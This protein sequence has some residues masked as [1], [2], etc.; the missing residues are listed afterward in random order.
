MRR[1]KE[2]HALFFNSINDFKSFLSE[3]TL[4]RKRL[5]IDPSSCGRELD[6]KVRFMMDKANKLE[7]ELTR[8]EIIKVRSLFRRAMCDCIKKSK[9]LKRFLEKPLGYP[10]D[11]FM[12]EMIYNQ[13]ILSKNKIG[14]YFDR[15]VLTHPVAQSMIERKECIKNLI[16]SFITSSNKK[17]LNILNLGCGSAR[18]LKELFASK[19]YSKKLI[20][21]LVDQDNRAL[22]Y[23][24]T[25]LSKI[26]ANNL[27]F[28]YHKKNILNIVKKEDL[29]LNN[30]DKY[31]LIYSIGLVDYFFGN[32][33]ENFINNLLRKIKNHVKI[34]IACCSTNSYKDFT[35]LKWFSDWNLVLRCPN[36]LEKYLSRIC[37]GKRVKIIKASSNAIFF[38]EISS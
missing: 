33:F 34:I 13:E 31:D 5:P 12:F 38:V 6:K 35:Y 21:E 9:I 3:S 24:K 25:N 20:F 10:G 37:N 1:I 19:K 22:N 11:Y 36:R 2:K 23:A 16:D 32:I 27:N 7:N 15:N 17:E 18:E 30:G 4:S 29:I 28:L 8:N 14:I 26:N